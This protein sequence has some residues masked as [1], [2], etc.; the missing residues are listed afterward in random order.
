MKFLT[1][2]HIFEVQNN[3]NW[4]KLFICERSFMM[5]IQFLFCFVHEK[6]CKVD[7]VFSFFITYFLRDV[8]FS[9]SYFPLVAVDN[10]IPE[11]HLSFGWK[12]EFCQFH[13][14]YTFD[15]CSSFLL[16][17]F[18]KCILLLWGSHCWRCTPHQNYLRSCY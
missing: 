18:V 5:Y 1:H 15:H 10:L 16:V 7:V 17:V 8:K 12:N 9:F 6:M 3:P 11:Q 13:P 14:Q 2:Q 4:L